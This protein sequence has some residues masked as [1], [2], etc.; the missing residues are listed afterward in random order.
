VG[1]V[2]ADGGELAKPA[3]FS[4]QPGRGVT[5]TVAGTRTLVGNGA[6][7]QGAGITVPEHLNPG[8]ASA[9]EVLVAR[10]SRLLGAIFVADG[11]R[12]EARQAIEA[13]QRMGMR[14]LLLTGDNLNVAAN[15][16]QQLGIREVEAELLPDAKHARVRQR[17]ASGRV[18]AMV[19]DGINDAPALAAADVG[20]AM[21]S[22][23]DVARECADSLLLGNDL[24][25]S[26]NPGDR[27]PDAAHHLAELCRDD[28]R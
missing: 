20:V 1:H 17:V 24:L 9:S 14:T 28:D 10:D 2:R 6:L 12:P 26:P 13:L 8:S 21:G 19:G 25:S 23:T 22:G 3:D 5:A 18:V 7:L 11:V 27:A 15:V 4:S 16:A